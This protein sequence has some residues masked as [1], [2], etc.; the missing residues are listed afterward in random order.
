MH[1]D[2]SYSAFSDAKG[3]VLGQYDFYYALQIVPQFTG[4]YADC[5]TTP[6][7]V[8][9]LK[10]LFGVETGALVLV[11]TD[12]DY[13]WTSGI[14]VN[15]LSGDSGLIIAGVG[16]GTVAT[17]AQAGNGC[18]FDTT[19]RPTFPLLQYGGGGIDDDFDDFS[20]KFI[21]VGGKAQS[22]SLVSS[23]VSLFSD[24]S[25]AARWASLANV[26]VGPVSTGVQNGATGFQAALQKAGT[27][28]N[29]ISAIYNLKAFAGNKDSVAIITIP[30][31]YG[32]AN[33]DG[34]LVI[35]VRRYGSIVLA[36]A[37]PTVTV[38][39]VFDNQELSNRQCNPVT[40]AQ[41]SCNIANNI[42]P[43]RM[44]LA[45]QLK[46]ID[47]NNIDPLS[48][49]KNLID[50]ND[51]SR[52]KDTFATCKGIRTVART[53]LHV[54]T[55]DEML[56]RWSFASEGGLLDALA[57]T[58]TDAKKDDDWAKSLGATSLAQLEGVC[59][60]QGDA[61]TLR[62]VEA[63]LG[64]KSSPPIAPLPDLAK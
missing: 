50:V 40:I 54:S 61:D 25:A 37:G 6:G 24:I 7:F 44:A 17:G 60:N 63:S 47:T 36:S 52:A 23:V 51:T 22:L 42:T 15:F 10:A 55:L 3:G 64:K 20:F 9:Y 18:L 1:A 12:V 38:D 11:K 32:D 53:V 34:N 8:D 27:L 45:S 46:P 48:P 43:I 62:K 13:R 58:G 49:V 39:T 31:L 35:Y 33:D 28:Q 5:H 14:K 16:P 41:G 30:K 4:K 29:Q 21:V 2:L 56:I 59:W 19:L 57:K 26:L